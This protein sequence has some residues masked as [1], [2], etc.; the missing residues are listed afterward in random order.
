MFE[1]LPQWAQSS[2]GILT[3]V[4]VCS[5]PPWACFCDHTHLLFRGR[6]SEKN[7]QLHVLGS[8]FPQKNCSLFCPVEGKP[9]KDVHYVALSHIMTK[10]INYSDLIL[11]LCVTHSVTDNW[12]AKEHLPTLPNRQKQKNKKR[13]GD[14]TSHAAAL[15]RDFS[16]LSWLFVTLST[17]FSYI[18]QGVLTKH[19]QS[20]FGFVT[21]AQTPWSTS[22]DVQSLPCMISII[23]SVRDTTQKSPLAEW[24]AS[25]KFPRLLT[26]CTVRR[27]DTEHATCT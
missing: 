21:S 19:F 6:R 15:I 16:I 23:W 5:R 2:Q 12:R 9:S 27:T 11:F 3:L 20:R 25:S 14:P 7:K 24:L 8:I 26:Q 22:Y 18:T 10:V 13:D 1:V 17:F 4:H